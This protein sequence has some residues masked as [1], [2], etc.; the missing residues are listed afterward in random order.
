MSDQQCP[1]QALGSQRLPVLRMSALEQSM[2]WRR[3]WLNRSLVVST[4]AYPWRIAHSIG[5]A[6]RDFGCIPGGV[7]RRSFDVVHS[8]ENVWHGQVQTIHGRP[9]AR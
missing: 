9:V 1:C 5:P 2:C 6:S 3:R 7:P 4:P 8:H